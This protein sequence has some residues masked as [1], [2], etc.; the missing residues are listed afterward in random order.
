VTG[1]ISH[2]VGYAVAVA[3]RGTSRSL[4]I[5]AELIGAVDDDV[6]SIAFTAAERR[7]GRALVDI[8]DDL[9]RTLMFS[10]KE[11]LFKAQY[12]LSRQWL[13]FDQVEIVDIVAHGGGT[14]S[15]TLEAP[16]PL[17]T[18]MTVEWPVRALWVVVDGVVIVGAIAQPV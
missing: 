9:G 18:V 10:A 4:G 16:A 11:A 8:P 5:D 2:T 1:S 6:A 17:E 12:P 14:G 3:A 15:V 7:R 13:D